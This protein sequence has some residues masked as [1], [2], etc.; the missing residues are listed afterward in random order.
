MKQIATH[1]Q[2]DT[3]V[4]ISL[5]SR[6]GCDYNGSLLFIMFRDFKMSG[7]E[8][9]QILTPNFLEKNV[10]YKNLNSSLI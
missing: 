5:L 7:S 1:D 10:S 4:L 8:S 9:Q 2:E 3:A 6:F